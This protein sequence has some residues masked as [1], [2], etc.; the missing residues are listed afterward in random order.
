MVFF[1]FLDVCA[2]PPSLKNKPGLRY[3]YRA[4]SVVFQIDVF[5]V[6][7]GFLDGLAMLSPTVLGFYGFVGFLN[8]SDKKNHFGAPTGFP[9]FLVVWIIC[10]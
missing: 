7:F 2:L 4:I 6:F 1:G 10:A 5:F 9:M 3:E 8:V